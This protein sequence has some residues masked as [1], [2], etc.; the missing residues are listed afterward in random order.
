MPFFHVVTLTAKRIFLRNF[1]MVVLKTDEQISKIKDS[2]KIVAHTLNFLK[3]IIR[4]KIPTIDLN[5]S[6]EMVI[7]QNKGIPGFKGYKG[8]PY[9]ICA[10]INDEVVHG[11][12]SNVL[13]KSGD[14]ISIDL[15]VIKEGWYGD[16]AF[17]VPVGKVCKKAEEIIRVTEECLYKGIEKALPYNRVGDISNAI[18]NH[19][20]KNGYYVVENYTGHGVGKNLHEKPQIPNLGEKGEGHLLLPGMV[21]AIE[22]IIKCTAAKTFVTDNNWTVKTNDNSLAAHFEHTVLITDGKPEILTQ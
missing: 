1:K 6:A 22:P 8:F 7:L 18:Q 21:I 10:S 3:K 5:R 19:A 9:S 12:P 13:L 16:A 15:G 20:E 4:E 2:C 17:T 11:F 14:I